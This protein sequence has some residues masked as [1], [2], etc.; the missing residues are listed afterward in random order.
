[1]KTVPAYIT[2]FTMMIFLSLNMLFWLRHCHWTKSSS[3]S[4]MDLV[5]RGTT[6]A[7]GAPINTYFAQDRKRVVHHARSFQPYKL[8]QNRD[9]VFDYKKAIAG[10]NLAQVDQGDPK[11]VELIRNYYIESPSSKP[12]NLTFP[13]RLENSNGQTPLVDSRLNYIVSIQREFVSVQIPV[14]STK[15]TK[16]KQ[17]MYKNTNK[18]F[19]SYSSPDLYEVREDHSFTSFFPAFK[20]N[21]FHRNSLLKRSHTYNYTFL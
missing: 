16:S 8:K 18:L 2:L 9:N 1:M 21:I 15:I 3:M 6:D 7:D 5:F 11:L 19:A 12:Y 14:I 13:D 10:M 17:K 4:Q 20:K